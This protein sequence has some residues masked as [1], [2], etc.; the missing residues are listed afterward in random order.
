MPFESKEQEEELRPWVC[1]PFNVVV[2][3]LQQVKGQ[4][5]ALEHALQDISKEMKVEP[6]DALECV[7][8]LPKMQ[9]MEDLQA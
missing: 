6:L 3:S 1:K 7:K 5:K 4:Y 8:K 2:D 9:D